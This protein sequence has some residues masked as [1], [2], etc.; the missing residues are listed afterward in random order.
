VTDLENTSPPIK[1]P[2][3]VSDSYGCVI[4]MQRQQPH[5]GLQFMSVLCRKAQGM[6]FLCLFLELLLFP[7]SHACWA[8][9][10]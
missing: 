2:E 9:S 5:Y 8:P 7:A 6:L 4:A 1:D 10:S 3:R